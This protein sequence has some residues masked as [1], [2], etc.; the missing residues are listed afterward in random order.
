MIRE[1][2]RMARQQQHN[3]PEAAI[4]CVSSTTNYELVQ[5]PPQAYSVL[6]LKMCYYCPQ[7]TNPPLE[8]C[9]LRA[10]VLKTEHHGFESKPVFLQKWPSLM[11]VLLVEYVSEAGVYVCVW[12]SPLG[13]LLG[14]RFCTC[15]NAHTVCVDYMGLL[16][17]HVHVIIVKTKYM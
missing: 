6:C 2:L 15:N 7:L 4:T 14:T 3:L 12:T 8:V 10:S 16:C 17:S 11:H 13:R 5:P 1:M 9:W